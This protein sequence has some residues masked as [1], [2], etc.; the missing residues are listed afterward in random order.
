MATFGLVH[1]AY[2]GAWCWDR[3][4]PELSRR[5]HE[6][7]TVDLPCET[8][9]CGAS[10]YAAAAITAF[11]DAPDDL[12]LVGHSL[13]GLTIPVVASRRPV[14]R[15]IFLCAMVARPGRAQDEAIAEEPD[16]VG[17]SPPG[18]AYLDERGASRWH[19]EPATGFFYSDC[20]PEDAAWAVALLRGQRWRI[21]AEVCPIDTWPAVPSS[22]VIGAHDPV[23]LPTW[24]RRTSPV[25]LGV[26]PVELDC[27]HSPFLSMP[28][29][30]AEVLE[31]EAGR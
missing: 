30:L 20:R 15:M 18:G 11:E 10:E 14:G 27:G 19:P 17:P 26:D 2:H 13:A 31:A 24:S 9:G 16:M 25:L 6:V 29:R 5:G 4:A 28:E 21:T 22:A 1:G 7:L 23:I 3:L 12:V 8:E